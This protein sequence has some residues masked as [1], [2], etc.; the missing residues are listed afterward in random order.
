M[1]YTDPDSLQGLWRRAGL[2]DVETSPL[3]VRADY[4]DFEDYWQPFLTGTG[5]GGK[6]CV[7]LDVRHQAALCGECSRRLGAPRGAF[8][9]AARAWAVRGVA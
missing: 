3:V 2:R 6:Y 8:T 4:A 5:P 7:S 1:S 9:L